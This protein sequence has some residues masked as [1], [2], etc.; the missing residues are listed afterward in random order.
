MR[1]TKD[2]LAGKSK[3]ELLAIANGEF[4][5]GL[6]RRYGEGSMIHHIAEAS[7]RV[8]SKDVEA[9]HGG[10]EAVEKA[11]DELPPGYAIIRIHKSQ[12]N[13]SGR[14]EFVGFQGEGAIIPVGIPVKIPEYLL[15]ILDNAYTHIWV[16]DPI[17]KDFTE[18]LSHRVPFTILKHNATEKWQRHEAKQDRNSRR[19]E[20]FTAF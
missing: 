2:D 20:E 13:P 5:L 14:P 8:G 9:L 10:K 3:D 1:Y 18:Q 7:A 19:M 11:K 4:N 16:E 12:H 6:D 17:T 15:E